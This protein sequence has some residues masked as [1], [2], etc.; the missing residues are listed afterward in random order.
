MSP[1]EVNNLYR[2][3]R[4]AGVSMRQLVEEGNPYLMGPLDEYRY[5]PKERFNNYVSLIYGDKVAVC[6]DGNT[7]ALIFKDPLLAKTWKNLF[8]LMWDVL[9]QPEKSNADE[10]F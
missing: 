8:D 10:K 2:K 5:M 6:T 7:K 9:K 4:A 3:I 1:P